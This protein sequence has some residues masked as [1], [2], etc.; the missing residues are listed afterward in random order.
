MYDFQKVV[1]FTLELYSP[2]PHIYKWHSKHMEFIRHINHKH[3]TVH[4]FM[5]VTFSI[6]FKNTSFNSTMIGTMSLIHRHKLSTLLTTKTTQKILLHFE[7]T[8]YPN[9]IFYNTTPQV[10]YKNLQVKLEQCQTP[11]IL[12]DTRTII[13]N[14]YQLYKSSLESDCQFYSAFVGQTFDAE[15]WNL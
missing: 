9:Y 2:S 13:V 7:P 1:Q 12:P 10:Y 3:Q 4:Y 8:S 5:I 14:S 15:S 11:K 6:F